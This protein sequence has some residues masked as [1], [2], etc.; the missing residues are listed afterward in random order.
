LA[1]LHVKACGG[2]G[3]ASVSLTASAS[4][5]ALRI[6]SLAIGRDL[7]H[8]HDTWSGLLRAD[9]RVTIGPFANVA[10]AGTLSL[11]GTAAAP[12]IDGCLRGD[13]ALS[14]LAGVPASLHASLGRCTSGSPE[15]AVTVDGSVT[16]PT[17][18]ATVHG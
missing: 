11:G 17:A 3:D 14:S 6:P 15:L 5:P 7:V 10:L 12:T 8:A 18:T 2:Y 13:A 4:F 1:N 9:G 16:L